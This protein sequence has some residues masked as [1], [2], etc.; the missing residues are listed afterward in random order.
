MATDTIIGNL[1]NMPINSI[2]IAS[3]GTVKLKFTGNSCVLFVM[4]A[5]ITRQ[6]CVFDYWSTASACKIVNPDANDYMT[7]TK[8]A[9]TKEV[10]IE[11]ASGTGIYA[12][13]MIA[14]GGR[15]E[16]VT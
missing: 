2:N 1:C 5:N 3:G 15:F 6:I 4:R 7:Y 13:N 10:T 12:A 14:I 8:T 9:N 11:R 16:E